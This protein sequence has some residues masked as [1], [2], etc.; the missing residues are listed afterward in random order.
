M[1]CEAI[2]HRGDLTGAYRVLTVAAGMSGDLE[3][4]STALRELRRAQPNVSIDWIAN[5]L[6]WKS[7]DDREH[8]LEGFRRAGLR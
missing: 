2:R 1:A 6:P 5:R 4:A 7:D 8:Y 3:L